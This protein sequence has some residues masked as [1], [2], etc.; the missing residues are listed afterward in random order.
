MRKRE[1]E[2]ER[3]KPEMRDIIYTLWQSV[4]ERVY[5]NLGKERER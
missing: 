1:R 5:V 3:K 4:M 2:I